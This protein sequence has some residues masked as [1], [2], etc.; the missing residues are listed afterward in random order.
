M[1]PYSLWIL[2]VGL[3]LTFAWVY[4]DLP[5]GPGAS[6]DYSMPARS[7]APAP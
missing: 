2:I 6:V 7:A 3:G 1:I 4:A 5:L